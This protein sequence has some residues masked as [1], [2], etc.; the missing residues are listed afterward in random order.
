[1]GAFVAVPITAVGSAVGAEV[2]KRRTESDPRF[3]ESVPEIKGA[4]TEGSETIV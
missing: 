3:S 2:W 4:K 1:V